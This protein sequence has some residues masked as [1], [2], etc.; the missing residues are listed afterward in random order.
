[1]AVI[2]LTADIAAGGEFYGK[3]TS[4]YAVTF[5]ATATALT[6]QVPGITCIN[7]GLVALGVALTQQRPEVYRTLSNPVL[8][9]DLV[10]PTDTSKLK[11]TVNGTVVN[12]SA[13]S[14]YNLKDLRVDYDTKSLNF[15]EI[16]TPTMGR[17]TFAPEQVV[18]LEIDFGSGLTKYFKGK[19]RTRRHQGENNNEAI[20]YEALGFQNVANDVT[21]LNTDGR[22]DVLFTVGSTVTSG[23]TVATAF[24]KKVSE[25]I[26]DLFTLCATYLGAEGIPA[27]IGYPGLDRFTAYLPE[28]VQIRNSGF[29]SALQQ[30][31]SHEPGVKA[32]FDDPTQTWVFPNLLQQPT[33]NL[34]VNSVN[35]QNLSYD[36]DASDRYTAIRLFADPSAEAIITH[37]NSMTLGGNRGYIGRQTVTLEQGWITA[38]ERDTTTPDNGWDILRGSGGSSADEIEDNY[39]W[40]FRRYRIPSGIVDREPGTPTRVKVRVDTHQTDPASGVVSVVRSRWIPVNAN[41]NFKR[42]IVV[43]AYPA[44]TDN[45]LPFE[46]SQ[47]FA[48]PEVTLTYWPMGVFRY[49]FATSVHSD[50]TVATTATTLT[51]EAYTSNLRYPGTGYTGTAY[52]MFGVQREKFEIVNPTEVTTANA[53]AKL[54]ALKDVKINAEIPVDGDPLQ[55]AINLQAKLIVTHPS[56]ATGISTYGA[57]ITG[58]R[59]EFGQRGK[60]VISLSTDVAGLVKL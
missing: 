14:F 37:D 47:S 41:I 52:E 42:R 20:D 9:G 59:Y 27:T 53:I 24:T 10:D 29:F 23:T 57:T 16:A 46:R 26:Q 49:T 19:I 40:V 36:Q 39:F 55:Y 43:L 7:S 12:L 44:I 45:S 60:N 58:Y 35:F 5:V 6:S 28:T 38:L 33:L 25:A 30:L 18:Q 15:S 34:N 54:N 50:G 48:A 1:M 2:G 8:S 21:V 56:L 11:L 3:R 22:P 13:S 32:F 51:N 17:A 4:D 31:A